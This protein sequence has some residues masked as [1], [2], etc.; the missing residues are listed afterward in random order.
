MSLFDAAAAWPLARPVVVNLERRDVVIMIVHGPIRTAIHKNVS[1]VAV[2]DN[3]QKVGN[4]R[5]AAT[6]LYLSCC[7]YWRSLGD[8]NPCFRRERARTSFALSGILAS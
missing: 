7:S 6:R 3:R 5:S 1:I 2:T 8:S 4:G